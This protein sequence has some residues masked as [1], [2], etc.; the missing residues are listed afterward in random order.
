MRN[1]VDAGRENVTSRKTCVV[2]G[3]AEA[4]G[5]LDARPRLRHYKEALKP[6]LDIRVSVNPGSPTWRD[7][8]D[9]QPHECPDLVLQADVHCLLFAACCL[10][11]HRR[12]MI[13]DPRSMG[14]HDADTAFCV[15]FS[16]E[17]HFQH[18]DVLA[19]GDS[20]TRVDLMIWIWQEPIAMNQ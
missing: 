15:L 8:R 13:F 17:W 10:L 6:R 14:Q 7:W 18:Q 5:K 3:V 12:G 20:M 4:L 16:L 19:F 9:G 2:Y 11:C 1:E